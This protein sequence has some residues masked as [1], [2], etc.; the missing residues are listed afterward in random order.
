MSPVPGFPSLG[1]R[2]MKRILHSLGYCAVPNSGP[3]SHETL[4]CKGRP[5]I[6]W[7]FH[8]KR[9]LAPIEV[10]NVLIKQAKLTVD[11]ARRA[12]NGR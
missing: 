12:V 7:A 2:K 11:E 9:E 1:A 5:D 4:A 3:G 10:R 8:D 6:R